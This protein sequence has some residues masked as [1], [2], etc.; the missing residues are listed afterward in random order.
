[1]QFLHALFNPAND[2]KPFDGV[3]FRN[4]KTGGISFGTKEEPFPFKR[5]GFPLST[6]RNGHVDGAFSAYV[7]GGNKA[8]FDLYQAEHA[9]FHSAIALSLYSAVQDRLDA[10]Q[11]FET[12][13]REAVELIPLMV[14]DRLSDQKLNLVAS[15]R[16]SAEPVFDRGH[17][18]A[19]L[20]SPEE[21]VPKGIDTPEFRAR[22]F[23]E[24]L[25][26]V[27][28][29]DFNGFKDL[30]AEDITPAKL[31]ALQAGFDQNLSRVQAQDHL[32]AKPSFDNFKS[33]VDDEVRS[34]RL[35]D[36]NDRPVYDAYVRAAELSYLMAVRDG[37]AQGN[38][39]QTAYDDAFE[40]I[41]EGVLGAFA[42]RKIDG[43]SENVGVQSVQNFIQNREY[44]D[45]MVIIFVG[46]TA[47]AVRENRD[48]FRDVDP[49][50]LSDEN[51]EQLSH[52]LEASIASLSGP[53][54]V[55]L[56]SGA[57]ADMRGGVSGGPSPA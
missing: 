44:D 21:I 25:A 50:R 22:F 54:A 43:R 36:Y 17:L 41:P 42:G 35:F 11:D 56:S 38:D 52:A 20:Y 49:A 48:M 14:F 27:A 18:Q 47:Q 13:R 31:S 5:G 19:L 1:M 4:P 23:V 37:L 34:T 57:Q 40:F 8:P 7:W 30:K 46:K 53:R 26:F 9:L 29:A 12:A 6:L 33:R 10:G 39:P 32:R 51:I 16:Q 2:E 24:K 45:R 3:V 55:A 15:F 28:K